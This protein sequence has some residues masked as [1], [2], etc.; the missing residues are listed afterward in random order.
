MVCLFFCLFFGGGR[1]F[2]TWPVSK[3][4]SFPQWYS[5]GKRQYL[6]PSKYGSTRWTEGD[7]GSGD[8][9]WTLP[10]LRPLDSK[11]GGS[12]Q[13][14][15]PQRVVT[16]PTQPCA[17][18]PTSAAGTARPWHCEAKVRVGTW[19][20]EAADHG[21][22]W[23]NTGRGKMATQRQSHRH[24]SQPCGAGPSRFPAPGD[25]RTNHPCMAPGSPGMDHALQPWRELCK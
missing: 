12:C 8:P 16:F 5:S 15:Y 1:G 22:G 6:G 4:W 18:R 21:G 24:G 3:Y 2:L 19:T 25:I 11:G 23:R 10:I 7:G 13:G 17:S 20:P 9:A 14:V